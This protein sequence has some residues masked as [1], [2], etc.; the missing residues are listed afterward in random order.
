MW[1]GTRRLLALTITVPRKQLERQLSNDARLALA[2]SG[3]GTVD[4]LLDES[5]LCAY[6]HLLRQHGGPRWDEA[7]F[8]ELRELVRADVFYEASVV[9]A[10]AAQAI[11]AAGTATRKIDD[12][13]A[14]ALQLSADDM[15]RQLRWL[16]HPGFVTSTGAERL[17]DV[18]RYVEGISVR[19]D[20][21]GGDA[22]R[23]RAR[24]L[25]IG[26]LQDEIDDLL[27]TCPPSRRRELLDVRWLVEELRI[28][29]F[30]QRLGTS[31]PISEQ[32]IVRAL[33]ALTEG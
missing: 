32:R 17:P 4:A 18:A 12:L 29:V 31:G 5:L 19:I 2:G 6:D 20:K 22:A 10:S 30:A 7:G 1:K 13:R 9:I 3:M 25:P 27:L 14:E 26:R 15:R 8:A 33:D 21:L 24:L 16:V 28:S 23:D 11:A